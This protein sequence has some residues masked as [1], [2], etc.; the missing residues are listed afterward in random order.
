MKLP[1]ELKNPKKELINIK[2]SAQKCFVWCHVRHINPVK[3]HPERITR[4]DK[5]LLNDLNYD[6]I[7]FPV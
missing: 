7:K 4:E 1:A 3:M 2:N 5:K 6:E